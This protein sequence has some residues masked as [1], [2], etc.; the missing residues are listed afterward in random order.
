[1]DLVDVEHARLIF[2]DLL[3]AQ[4]VRRCQLPTLT[5]TVQL[6]DKAIEIAQLFRKAQL[7]PLQPPRPSVEKVLATETHSAVTFAD[8]AYEWMSCGDKRQASRSKQV[9]RSRFRRHVIPFLG[10]RPVSIIEPREILS[11]V[12]AIEAAG[13]HRMAYYTFHD[14]RS[15]YRYAIAHGLSEED[16]TSILT[17]AIRQPKPKDFAMPMDRGSIG[18]LLVA[19]SR[20]RSKPWST[21][22]HMLR[23]LPMVFLRASELRT[24]EWSF[25]DLDAAMI[26]I[27][28]NRM[29][30]GRPH[31]VPLARQA[32]RILEDVQSITGSG[33]FVFTSRPGVDRPM[34]YSMFYVMLGAIGFRGIVSS[35]GFRVLASSWLNEQGWRAD[36]IERQL[37]HVGR[38]PVR[39]R[40]NLADYLPER[41]KMMQAWADHLENLEREASAGRKSGI[42]EASPGRNL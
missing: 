1:M 8:V 30:S 12:R 33:H 10:H 28:G 17:N 2:T 19:I 15:I 37:A 7:P 29:K 9:L 34:D 40:Y 4:A 35:H 41:R 26:A 21:A 16:P 24:L 23:L 27:P 11:V 42:Q 22:G 25:V 13:H 5:E 36:A 14:I 18:R 32:V 20:Y 31:V 38:G 3:V 6:V 39:H